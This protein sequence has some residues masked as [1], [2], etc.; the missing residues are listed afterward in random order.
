MHK[1]PDWTFSNLD[2][3]YTERQAK[4]TKRKNKKNT[5]IIYIFYPLLFLVFCTYLER[6]PTNY[7]INDCTILK[8]IF[9]NVS[10]T[11][12]DSFLPTVLKDT[13]RITLSRT[14]KSIIQ[15]KH[16]KRNNIQVSPFNVV[17]YNITIF[18]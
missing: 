6:I 8:N 11:G 12:I 7:A 15:S 18:Q 13:T 9:I 4:R 17:F 10:I 1:K 5:T 2:L 3:I 14:K 16:P